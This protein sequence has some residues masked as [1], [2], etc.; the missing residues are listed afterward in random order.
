MNR[1]YILI[2]CAL[3]TAALSAA[4]GVSAES[5]IRNGRIA[6]NGPLTVHSRNP[7]Y[8][9]DTRGKA[10]YLTGSHYWYNLQDG[11][12]KT[13]IT[14]FDY[15][16]YL[17]FIERYNH[18]F[19]RLWAWEHSAWA[20]WTNEKVLF[21]PLPYQRTGPGEALDGG[22]KFD[23][24]AFNQTYF[25]RLRERALRASDRGIYVSVMLFQGWSL[26]TKGMNQDGRV[27]GALRKMS[28]SIGIQSEFLRKENNP[29]KGH[30]FNNLNNINGVSGDLDQDGEGPEVH[31][32]R[33]PIVTK[34]QEKY[35]RKMIDTLNDLDN[36]LWEIS[37]ES[38]K[39]S[40]SWQYHM[41]TFI[42]KYEAS[43]PKKH[44]V[45]MTFQYPQGRNATLFASPAEAVSP[46]EEEGY[47]E[48]AKPATGE[49][50]IIS[51]TDHLWGIGGNH[52]WV[53]KS[54]LRGLHPIC[55]DYYTDEQWASRLNKREL[56]YIRRNMGYTLKYATR[57]NLAAMVPRG[58]LVSTGYCLADPRREFLVYLPEGG[59]TTIDLSMAS[60]SLSVEWFEPLSG[61]TIAAAAVAGGAKRLLR[62]PFAGDSVLYIGKP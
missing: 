27:M 2:L 59:E 7:R 16:S 24:N 22:L 26:E 5:S 52:K 48:A 40:T 42:K 46:N 45:L 37:N 3:W 12:N 20:P 25:D 55:M 61:T 18:N 43:K 14:P 4:A 1:K 53:W 41:I 38:H 39:G 36:I 17:D 58:D 35:V 10:I 30:P 29:W 13:R 8:F 21:D 62:S 32:L 44:P 15:T 34:I 60:A 57:I 6:G 54:F 33:N 50:I 47:R 28:N 51:D 31:T 11:D 9:T 49:K 23:L 56:E 19:I